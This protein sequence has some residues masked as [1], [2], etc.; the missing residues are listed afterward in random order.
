MTILGVRKHE[1]WGITLWITFFLILGTGPKS[2]DWP[3]LSR[4]A[5]SYSARDGCFAEPQKFRGIPMTIRNSPKSAASVFMPLSY[6]LSCRHGAHAIV[7]GVACVCVHCS[8]ELYI[9]AQVNAVAA[10]QYRQS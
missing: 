3:V 2:E 6:G 10:K 4:K 9:S 7:W 1:L 8:I 5:V